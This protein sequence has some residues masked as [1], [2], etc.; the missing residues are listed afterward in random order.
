M[1]GTARRKSDVGL[2]FYQA[3]HGLFVERRLTEPWLQRIVGKNEAFDRLALNQ[4]IDNLRDVR[5]RDAPVK[6]VIGF[7]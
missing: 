4:S 6:K 3:A 7:D 1:F 2:T 5:D